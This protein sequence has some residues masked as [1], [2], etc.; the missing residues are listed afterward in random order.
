MSHGCSLG[1][2]STK[3]LAINSSPLKDKGNTALI[4]N[5]F[6]DGMKEAGAEVELYYTRDLK[7]NPCLGDLSCMFRTPGKCIHEDDI[8][9]LQMKVRQADVI[10]LASPVYC[11]SV[12]GPMKTL[13]DRLITGAHPSFEIRDGHM[14][15]PLRDKA[16]RYEIVLVSNCGYWEMDN[17]DPLLG[18]YQSILKERE[19]RFCRCPA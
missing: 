2:E 19:C 6:L 5:P 17:F 8:I 11:D 16:K 15:H 4:L 14:R 3:V 18:A 7:I 9:W 10:V 13:M 1:G 12:T